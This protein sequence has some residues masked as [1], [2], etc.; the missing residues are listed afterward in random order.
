[1]RVTTLQ[2]ITIAGKIIHPGAIIEIPETVYPKLIGK[3]TPLT[4]GRNLP[5]WCEPGLCWCSE[6]LPGKNY[7]AGCIAFGC[8]HHQVDH[9]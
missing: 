2:Q 8:E 5:H 7:P 3:V 9:S 6:K 4:D 1:M